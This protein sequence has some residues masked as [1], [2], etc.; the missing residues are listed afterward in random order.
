MKCVARCLKNPMVWAVLLSLLCGCATHRNLQFAPPRAFNFQRDTFA[1][2]NELVWTYG[3]D[4]EGKWVSHRREPK[5]NYAQHCFI[6]ARSAQQFFMSARF[7]PEQP[8]VD[9]T[10]YRQLIHRVMEASPRHPLTT[11]KQIVIPGYPDLRAFSQAHE[12]LL[13]EECGGAWQSYMQRGNW[14]M[15]FPFT[16]H[17]QAEMAEQLAAGLDAT[18]PAVV[19]V[20]RFPQLSINHA[21]LLF[22]AKKTDAEIQFTAYDP[23]D[24]SAPTSVTF[25][26]KTRSFSLPR[27]SYFPGGQVN[28]Y[29][30]YHQWDY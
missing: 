17:E 2:P 1:Y 5:P 15:I 3:Y 30:V 4:A 6:L 26:R 8:P 20:V 12:K 14:R 23:N 29:Q 27:S 13:K 16:R 7:A 24:P 11:A 9:E 28:L 10:S 21:L 22:A 25:E 18:G 19:H